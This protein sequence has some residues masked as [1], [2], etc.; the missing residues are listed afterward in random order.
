MKSGKR[1]SLADYAGFLADVVL[2]IDAARRAAARAVNAGMTTA[3]WLIGRRI[4]E[5]EQRGTVRADY[6]EQLVTRLAHD[7]SSRFGRGFSK[8]NLWQMRECR[9][10]VARAGAVS[11]LG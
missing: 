11:A 4:V 8:R 3:Y 5:E 7:L 1:N 9:R 2:V 6:G 10:R